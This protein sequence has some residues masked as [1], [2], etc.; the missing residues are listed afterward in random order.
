MTRN[1]FAAFGESGLDFAAKN[2]NAADF[3]REMNEREPAVRVRVIGRH[4]E[5][6]D[7]RIVKPE[8]V[9]ILF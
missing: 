1:I 9:R 2:G 3:L 8:K 6:V 5:R 4:F 7:L